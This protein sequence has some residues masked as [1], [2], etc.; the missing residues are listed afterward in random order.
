MAKTVGTDL[1]RLRNQLKT[2]RDYTPKG[3]AQDRRE[4]PQDQDQV[5]GLL[6][7]QSARRKVKSKDAIGIMTDQ[8]IGSG[9]NIK[10]R[11]MPP[12]DNGRRR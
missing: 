1:A 5:R 12:T 2:T 7:A 10:V 9:K 8:D 6:R 3:C 4:F 11:S